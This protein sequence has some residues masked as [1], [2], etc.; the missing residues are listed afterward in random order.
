MPTILYRQLDR[1]P[2]SPPQEVVTQVETEKKYPYQVNLTNA[3][4]KTKDT[5]FLFFIRHDIFALLEN[6]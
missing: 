1:H 6:L 4:S 2:G 5:A 3:L